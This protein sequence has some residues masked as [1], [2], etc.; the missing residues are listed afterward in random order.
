MVIELSNDQKQTVL[1]LTCQIYHLVNRVFMRKSPLER[2]REH[3]WVLAMDSDNKP[4]SLEE[5]RLSTSDDAELDPMQFFRH[6][7]YQC[8]T[9]AVLVHNHPYGTIKPSREDYYLT[10]FLL[11]AG[12]ILGIDVVDHLIISNHDIFYSFENWGKIKQL[13]KKPL[14]KLTRTEL[15]YLRREALHI[16]HKKGN[17]TVIKKSKTRKTTDR[18]IA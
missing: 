10:D 12:K 5:I 8:A 7:L 15:A 4:V 16:D 2:K 11:Q 6:P 9:K 3:F 1:G 17:A 13:N 14:F 18:F